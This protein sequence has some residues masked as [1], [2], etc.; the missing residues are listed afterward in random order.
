MTMASYVFRV[1]SQIGVESI[2]NQKADLN[3]GEN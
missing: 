3:L 2:E 1:I